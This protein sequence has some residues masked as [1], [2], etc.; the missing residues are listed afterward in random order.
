MNMHHAAMRVFALLVALGG[1]GTSP[2]SRPATL[3][4]ITHEV[5]APSCGQVQ[6]HSTTTRVENYALDTVPAARESLARLLE[7]DDAGG[8]RLFD[9]LDG[10]GGE[11]M[12]ADAPLPQAD[13]DLLTKW[14]FDNNHEGVQ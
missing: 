14:Y 3:E 5:L 9:I 10:I 8:I 7:T 6:C 11:R 1:C 2:D 13:R 12:P 4:T